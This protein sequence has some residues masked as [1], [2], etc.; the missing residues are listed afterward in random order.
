[1]SK[2]STKTWQQQ[3]RPDWQLTFCRRW[4]NLKVETVWPRLLLAKASVC[5]LTHA[6][7]L[8]N[9]PRLFCLADFRESS[10]SFFSPKLLQGPTMEWHR[11]D[12]FIPWLCGTGLGGFWGWGFSEAVT[13]IQGQLHWLSVCVCVCLGIYPEHACPGGRVGGRCVLVG[14][15]EG[16]AIQASV[17]NKW[18]KS[19]VMRKKNGESSL[20]VSVP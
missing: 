4:Y 15:G 19:S 17:S 20:S 3:A 18:V 11:G 14:G 6:L 5:I 7:F 8:M 1:M 2:I 13:S 12:K 16:L 9:G 10:F